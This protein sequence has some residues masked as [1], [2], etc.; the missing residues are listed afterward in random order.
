M[1]LVSVWLTN[2]CNYSCYYCPSKPYMH[3]TNFEFEC[4][5][6]DRCPLCRSVDRTKACESAVSRN[7]NGLLLPWLDKYLDPREW[8]VE[9]MGGEPGLYPE[10]GTLVPELEGRG[11]HGV[12]K[13]NGSLPIPY[14]GN[15]VRVAAWHKD[16]PFPK[17]YDVILVIKN[18]ED[19]WAA[20]AS[21][22]KNMGI[23]YKTCVFNP[24]YRGE[25]L[26][27]GLHEDSKITEYMYVN[28]FGQI[29]PC[30]V[31]GVDK[32]KSIRDMDE[33]GTQKNMPAVCPK[34]VHTHS[35][36]RFLSRELKDRIAGDYEEWRR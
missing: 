13:T 24:E 35:V 32:K 10:I 16:R 18:P 6:K 23:D 7:R 17:Y 21:H 31:R 27:P 15:F 3:D 36:E 2:K 5:E 34:C 33:P 25:S 4:Q 20:K 19:D 22:C 26:P 14:S 11:Y 12:I 29:S 9:L 1:K 28:C 8:L 30:P